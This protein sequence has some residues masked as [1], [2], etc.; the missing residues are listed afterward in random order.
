VRPQPF[1]LDQL[2][3]SLQIEQPRRVRGLLLTGK[4]R[5]EQSRLNII[6]LIDEQLL[7]RIKCRLS[8][9]DLFDS[10]PPPER[11]IQ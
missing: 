5:V 7:N 2:E 10:M 1:L 3:T 6:R 4:F 9:R 8:R 11:K